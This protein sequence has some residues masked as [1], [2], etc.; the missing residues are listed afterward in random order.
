MKE[1]YGVLLRYLIVAAMAVT[2]M[3]L[4]S[5]TTGQHVYGNNGA[6]YQQARCAA[7]Q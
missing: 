3:S 1:F 2:I 4:A 7:Y 5:C 6:A